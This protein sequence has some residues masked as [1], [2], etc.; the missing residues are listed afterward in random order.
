MQ[1]HKLNS[2]DIAIHFIVCSS[3]DCREFRHIE[4]E[5]HCLVALFHDFREHFSSILSLCIFL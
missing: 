1:A 5:I 3:P 2:N 4:K